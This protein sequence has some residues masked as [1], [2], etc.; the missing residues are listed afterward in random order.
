MPGNVLA[1]EQVC[2]AIA[3][4]LGQVG[5]TVR[6]E[7]L[8]TGRYFSLLRRAPNESTLE[9]VYRGFTNSTGDPDYPLRLPFSTDQFAPAGSNRNFYSNSEVDALL[10]I[11]PRTLRDN[12]RRLYYERIQQIVWNDQS[13]VY[14]AFLN[15]IAAGKTRLRGAAIL[16]FEIVHFREASVAGQ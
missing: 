4:M 7:V 16:P 6:L 8:E 9:M 2:Q 15:Q 3:S 12:H 13:W 10:D 14:V 5:I 1:A 11:A